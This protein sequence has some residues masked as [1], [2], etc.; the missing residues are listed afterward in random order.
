MIVTLQS[1]GAKSYLVTDPTSEDPGG[2]TAADLASKSGYE[3]LAAFLA[4]KSLVEHF[5]DMKVAGNATGSLQ[6]TTDVAVIP[7]NFAE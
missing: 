7:G 6:T 4:E 3:G 5:S 2:V 1:A